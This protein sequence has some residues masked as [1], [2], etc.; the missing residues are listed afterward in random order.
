[1]PK[2]TVKFLLK[3]GLKPTLAP[4]GSFNLRAATRL[5]I[6][7]ETEALI[8]LGLSCDRSVQIFEAK[9]R[10]GTGLVFI[11]G[12]WQTQDS[13]VP[14]KLA[15]RN[16]SKDVVLLEVGDTLARCHILDNSDVV[17]E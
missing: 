8:D 16:T 1:M 7:P 2:K 12:L 4:D 9:S 6:R 10:K 17:V 5:A 15:V 13:G 14:L 11:P 3:D